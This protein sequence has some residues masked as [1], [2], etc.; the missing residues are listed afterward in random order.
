MDELEIN[1][2]KKTEEI[3]LQIRIDYGY[4]DKKLM[5]LNYVHVWELF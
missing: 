1:L 4:F 5:F 2:Y 3:A